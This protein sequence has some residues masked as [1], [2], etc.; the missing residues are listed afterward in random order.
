MN[1]HL[2]KP[3][4]LR[5]FFLTALACVVVLPAA[6]LAEKPANKKLILIAG[7]PSHGP[8]LHEF[9]AGCLLFQKCLKGIEGLEVEVHNNHWVSDNAVLET[10]D[11]VVIYADGGKGHPALQDNRRELLQKVVNRGGGIMMMHYA[12]EC[13]HDEPATGELFRDWIGG[14]YETNFS[15]NPIWDADFKKFPQ[16]PIS[17]GVDPFKINDEWYFS[18]RFPEGMKG[19]Q[20]ILVATPSDETR[21]GPY[22]HPKGPYPHIQARKG[23]EETMMWCI[24][25][26][27]G[28]RG[29]GFTGGHFHKNWEDDN[30]RKVV[31]NAM[32]W[33]TKI[34]VPENGV[35]SKVTE[36]DMAA[37]LDPKPARKK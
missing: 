36:V 35:E 20:S 21:D 9:N 17:R 22:V 2:M 37:N 11:A 15:A 16:H 18:I 1:C 6:A 3:S 19:V 25:R 4:T 12:V 23:E 26:K 8:G 13:S 28:G 5:T 27:D 31:L 29:V 10:A 32:L 30:M 34:E 24:E 7:R 14:A 33:I